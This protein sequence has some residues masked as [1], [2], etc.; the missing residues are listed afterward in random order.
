MRWFIR[1]STMVI[2]S[3]IQAKNIIC[4]AGMIPITG[5]QFGYLDMMSL[6]YVIPFALSFKSIH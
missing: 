6:L 4:K 5:K 2:Q 1:S 3:S